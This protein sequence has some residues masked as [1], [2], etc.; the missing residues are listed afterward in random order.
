MKL[1]R[2]NNHLLSEKLV[3]AMG[4]NQFISNILAELAAVL[5]ENSVLTGDAVTQRATSYWDPSPTTALALL[6]PRSTEEV[7]QVMTICHRHGQAVVTHGGLTGCVEGAVA[8]PDEIIISLERMNA[9]EAIDRQGGTAVVQAGAILEELHDAVAKEQLLFP[10]DLGSRGS[11]TI[12]GNIAT[13]AGGINVLRYGMMRSLVLGLEVVTADGTVIS[14][15]N[16][17]LKNNAG[18]DNKQLFIGSEGTLGIVTRA[19]LKLFPLPTSCNTALV[20]LEDFD[21]VV[22]LLN[23]LQRDLAGTLSAYEVM[24]GEYFRGVTGDNGHRSPMNREYAFY[25]ILEAQGANASGDTERF[26]QLLGDALENNVIVD[27]V[28]P[29][30]EL[31]RR[32]LWDIREE[33]DPILP[34]ILYDISLPIGSMAVYI[35]RVMS[36]L[37]EQWPGSDCFVLGHIADGNLHLFVRPNLDGE[38]HAECDAIVYAPLDGL[39]GSESA[40]HGIGTEKLDWLQSS[41]SDA[42]IAMMRLL[43]Q[44]L[45]P[46]GLLNAGR[47]LKV[48]KDSH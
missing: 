46:Q 17:M 19:V 22:E 40:E 1:Q 33:F 29:K 47:V 4:Q 16:Q 41:R 37:Q 10:L 24:W 9:I 25:V 43:K 5:G 18:Y 23:S 31:E 8:R 6:K 45:D 13:N 27:A 42:D 44:T 36:G 7:S 32:A 48:A 20:A 21:K 11:C 38:H 3:P 12:G 2:A 26:E 14:S 28:L 30:S 39:N 15:M 35:E 34:A